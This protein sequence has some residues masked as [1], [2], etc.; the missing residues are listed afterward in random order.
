[1]SWWDSIVDF[2]KSVIG[3]V[4]DFFGSNSLGSNLAKTALL[5][6]AT[7]KIN[8]S[9]NADNSSSSSDFGFPEIED[10]GIRLQLDPGT[11]NRIPVLYGSATFGGYITDAYLTSD[12]KTMYY[13]ITLSEKTGNLLSTGAASTYV[14]NDI[15][16]NGNRIIFQSNGY[17]A[18]YMI[19]ADGQQDIS[20]RDIVRVYCYAGSSTSGTVPE[21]YLGSIDAAYNILPHWT[22][23]HTMNDLIFAVVRIDYNRDKGVVGV[24]NMKFTITNSMKL[25]GDCMYDYMTN[26]RYGAAIDANEIDS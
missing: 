1:M 22:N 6:Y 24:P 10:P 23:R 20:I 26:T 21:Y 16:L 18:D 19:N 12:N 25:P 5:G 7:N 9:I 13:V 17:T 8:K 11:D 14:F 4:T 15:Y 3:G 2:G